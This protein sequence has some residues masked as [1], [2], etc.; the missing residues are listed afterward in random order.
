M[1]WILQQ[2]HELKEEV[3]SIH[4]ENKLLKISTP[5]V[6]SSAPMSSQS[7]VSQVLVSDSNSIINSTIAEDV[8]EAK[9]RQ[10]SVVKVGVFESRD[11]LTS[12][13]FTYDWIA[14]GKSLIIYG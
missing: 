10:R 2:Y 12:T 14:R 1:D 8:F 4:A 3:I 13:R 5:H 6:D 9:E 11:P 7:T